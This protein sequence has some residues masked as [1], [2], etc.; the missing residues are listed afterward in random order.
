MLAIS[1]TLYNDVSGSVSCRDGKP[2]FDRG[3][4]TLLPEGIR[5]IGLF[6]ANQGA[7]SCRIQAYTSIW[8]IKVNMNEDVPQKLGKALC[9]WTPLSEKREEKMLVGPIVRNSFALK[10]KSAKCPVDPD[11]QPPV[12]IVE[13]EDEFIIKV[14]L[15]GI[16]HDQVCVKLDGSIITISGKREPETEGQTFQRVER[17]Y[18]TFT[19][20]FTVPESTIRDEVKADYRNGLLRVHLP[21]DP[22]GK[23]RSIN[24]AFEPVAR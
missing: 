24:V 14:E 19:R 18:G 16:R 10:M 11:W 5:K 9:Q 3:H 8:K 4:A 1:I 12:D 22:A 7:A 6:L 20:S 23:T 2:S 17:Q 13:C 21:K 15:P